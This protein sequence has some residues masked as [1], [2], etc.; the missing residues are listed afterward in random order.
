M[1]GRFLVVRCNNTTL[2]VYTVQLGVPQ[3]SVLYPILFM[4]VNDLPKIMN[5]WHITMFAD[6]T[7]LAISGPSSQM[8]LQNYSDIVNQF[9]AWCQQS[10]Y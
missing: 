9:D 2:K 7:T 1:E 4:F 10:I 3:G 6:D 5:N 8:V